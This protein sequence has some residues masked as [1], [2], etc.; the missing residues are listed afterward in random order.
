MMKNKF[1]FPLILFLSFSVQANSVVSTENMPNTNIDFW[2]EQFKNNKDLTEKGLN[3]AIQ[4]RDF[5]LINTFLSLY[6]TF[7]K[8]DQFLVL[9]AESLL[10][11]NEQNYT[12]S[13]NLLRRI[14]AINPKLNPVRLELAKALFLNQQNNEAQAQ[15]ELVKSDN[16]P[17]ALEQLIDLYLEA[18]QRRNR[19]YSQF[20]AYYTQTD[21]VNNVSSDINIGNTGFRKNPSMLPQ[22]AHGIAFSNNIGK[23]FNLI[24]THYLAL[25]NYLNGKYYWDNHDYT[26]I[27]DRL[28]LG[29]KYKNA[30]Q[31]LAILPFYQ[32]RWV[33]N[34]RYQ[35]S[36]GISLAWSHW[37]N[38]HFQL[39]NTLEY[40]KNKYS[41]TKILDGNSKSIS[42]TLFWLPKSTQFIYIG[43]DALWENT[44]EKQ[45]SHHTHSLRLGWKQEWKLGISSQINFSISKRKYHDQAVLGGILP[46]N[47]T[48][49]DHI[50][51]ANLTLWKRDWQWWNI[52]PKLQFNWKQQVSNIPSMYS[53]TDKNIN[54]L[55]E[56]Q[57]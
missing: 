26:D 57:F 38:N 47:K 8:P 23:D 37:L 45:Y 20:N 52:T 54:L 44:Q 6:L 15:F 55:F 11:Q 25:G 40:A 42:S 29:Y 35:Q 5:N 48:R 50:Y 36:Y 16:L 43:F 9:F 2:Q 51:Q 19:W 56:K 31:Q 1:L 41:Q 17:P 22:S 30:V 21:N 18:I 53:Y 7:P 13:I 4:Q 32:W 28:N 49:K 24:S 39:S 3:L 12:K 34:K 33:A 27:Q 10:A 14:L 46:L